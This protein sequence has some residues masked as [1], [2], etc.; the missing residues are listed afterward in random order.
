MPVLGPAPG[1]HS[2]ARCAEPVECRRSPGLA[3]PV[4]ST[5]CRQGEGRPHKLFPMGRASRAKAQARAA[6]TSRDRPNLLRQL[7][8]HV[9]FM[10]ASA[11]AFDSG[12]EAEA[13]RLAV[14]L[15]VL[16]H[17]TNSSRALL[18]QLG[19]KNKLRFTETSEP[20]DQYSL[21]P[22][23]GLVLM[24]MSLS[25]PDGSYVA[26]LGGLPPPRIKPPVKFDSW[27]MSTVYDDEKVAWSRKKFVLTLAN[28][29]GGAHVDP[30]LNAAYE[31]L[32]TANGLGWTA[33]TAA[34][35][36][37]FAGSPVA[38]SVRQIT[39]ELLETLAR[40]AYLLR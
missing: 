36:Q 4:V 31:R 3:A 26:P 7:R 6:L 2:A 39:Y 17:D 14:S 27:W 40:H 15:R 37:P 12:F 28:N 21:G 32:V 19:V 38:A 18:D 8:E 10:K 20:M 11:T 30:K 1:P 9:D 35:P 13:K 33:Q 23:P 5:A 24:R 22:T 25:V 16:L 29:E 34:G